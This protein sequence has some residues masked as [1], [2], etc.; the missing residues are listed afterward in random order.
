M[1]TEQKNIWRLYSEARRVEGEKVQG[2]ERFIEW[3]DLVKESEVSPELLG[4]VMSIIE[5]SGCPSIRFEDLQGALGVSLTTACVVNSSTLNNPIQQLFYV[6]FHEIAHQYQ[7]TK[8]GEEFAE[9]V[10]FGGGDPVVGARLLLKIEN[11]A[12]RYAYRIVKHLFEKHNLPFNK[13]TFYLAYKNMSPESISAYINNLRST[14]RQNNLT[15]VHEVNDLIY[16][17]IKAKLTE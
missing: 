14:I 5:R 15:N 13:K 7:Y 2:L 6:I 10:Y 17:M 16:N 4:D 8:H 9:A 1:L 12:D 3:I 11:T